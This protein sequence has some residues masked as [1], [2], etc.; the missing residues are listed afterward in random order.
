MRRLLKRLL[1][2]PARLSAIG[3]ATVASAVLHVI[4][5]WQLGRATDLV[6][7]SVS[8]HTPIDLGHLHACWLGWPRCMP[9]HRR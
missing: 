8:R 3:A 6:L 4:G 5:P 2:E 1:Q 7:S 9:A